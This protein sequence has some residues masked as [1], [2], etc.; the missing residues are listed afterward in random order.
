MHFSA[1]TVPWLALLSGRM[2]AV[3]IEQRVVYDANR[4]ICDSFVM[5]IV[6]S[7]SN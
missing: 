4:A 7:G 6:Y 1:I 2:L 3:C 5:L